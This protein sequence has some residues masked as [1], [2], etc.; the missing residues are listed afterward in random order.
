MI[1]LKLFPLVV[2]NVILGLFVL[3]SNAYALGNA[4]HYFVTVQEV[5][6]Q[7]VGGGWVT[8]ATPNQAVDICN[9]SAGQAAATIGA[10]IKIPAG[11]YNNF[12]LKLSSTMQFEGSDGVR[13]TKENGTITLTGGQDD[14]RAAS[15]VNWGAVTPGND[16]AATS[17]IGSYTASASENGLVTITLNLH[18]G[19]VDGYMEVYGA[20]N[21]ATPI[22][23]KEDSAISMWF[24]F[25]TQSTVGYTNAWLGSDI[26][27]L[28]PPRY[29]TQYSITVDG[30]TTA[31]SAND[32]RIDF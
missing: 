31:V 16:V 29:G 14:G 21:L 22:S 25:D 4:T 2:L 11:E 28:L 12:K 27:Y 18:N 1:K 9:V 20:V 30:V 24:D 3:M 15:T 13:Y 19:D 10:S 8:I 7:K 6:L 23:V 26:M 17:N 5:L 32:M